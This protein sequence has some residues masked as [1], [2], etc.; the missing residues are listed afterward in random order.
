MHLNTQV[1]S[2]NTKPKLLIFRLPKSIV[3]VNNH[4]VFFY[5]M[6]QCYSVNFDLEIIDEKCNYKETIDKVKPDIVLFQFIEGYDQDFPIYDY[7]DNLIPRVAVA[8]QDPSSTYRSQTF[9]LMEKYSI[10]DVFFISV[11]QGENFPEIKDQIFYLPH[12]I[13]ATKNADYKMHK[14][15]PVLMVGLFESSRKFYEWR[16]LVRKP[17]IN[18]FPALY[19]RHPGYNPKVII[20]E[21]LR[22]HG[23]KYFKVLSS[24]WVALTCGAYKKSLGM[25]HL[26]IPAAGTCLVCEPSKTV[27]L[28]GFKDMESCV[29]AEPDEIVDKLYYLFENPD[30]MQGIIDKG[31]ELVHSM[32]THKHRP[33]IWQWYNLMKT[34]K[35]NQKIIQ[36]SL[37]GDLELVDVD[38]PRETFHIEG[39]ATDIKDITSADG[40][41]ARKKY[42]K[43]E[44]KAKEVAAL[45]EYIHDAKL[46]LYL[47]HMLNGRKEY[48]FKYLK[49][50]VE[51]GLGANTMPDP[52]NFALFIIHMLSTNQFEKAAVYAQMGI[53]RRRPEL[54]F[55]RLLAFS[56]AGKKQAY[57]SLLQQ[58][59]NPGCYKPLKSMYYFYNDR[60]SLQETLEK[61]VRKNVAWRKAGTYKYETLL[62][63]RF[64][65]AEP[66]PIEQFEIPFD[67]AM[68]KKDLKAFNKPVTTKHKV[69]RKAQ[70]TIN[71]IIY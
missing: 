23:E 32:H 33:Q 19:F 65:N 63:K 9:R 34:K 7:E 61:I 66:A 45:G 64:Q 13:D 67:A 12:F 52:V 57:N 17:V 24:S 49:T 18:N 3:P 20:P 68:L 41:I 71:K 37:F 29:F 43:A 15:N 2:L 30:I 40:L 31:Y 6:D 70:D 1:N 25:K 38:S 48:G 62:K 16:S 22:V 21:P 8:L 42:V 27:E 50:I 47:I 14:F 39:Y 36:P 53:T 28:H 69:I 11:E 58:I 44:K 55:I 59:E 35:P 46:R 5:K 51:F 4:H 54:D 26:E 60:F 10:N 56:Q